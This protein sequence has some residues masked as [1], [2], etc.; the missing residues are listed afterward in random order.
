M[1]HPRAKPFLSEPWR[2]RLLSSA[3]KELI[4][5]LT[6]FDGKKPLFKAVP[7]MMVV[8]MVPHSGAKE[9]GNIKAM[10]DHAATAC[11]VQ[12]FMLYLA[13]CGYGTKWMTGAMGIDGET[14]LSKV[15]GL[16]DTAVE[17]EHYM[18]VIIMG[19]PTQAL[20]TINPPKRKKGL[21]N[22]IFTSY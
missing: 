20:D 6:K 19:S 11:A 22:G 16:E 5:N 21:D 8:S 13:S 7:Q 4:I 18:G 10:E 9:W 2:F 15:C 1:R 3:Q 17:Q 12:N 14:I